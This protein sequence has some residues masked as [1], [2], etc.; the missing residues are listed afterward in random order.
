[1]TPTPIWMLTDARLADLGALLIF[2]HWLR[3]QLQE[4][5]G[6]RDEELYP[7]RRDHQQDGDQ[8]FSRLFF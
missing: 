5:A 8:R 2:R 7:F 1:M 3:C 4:M 6:L